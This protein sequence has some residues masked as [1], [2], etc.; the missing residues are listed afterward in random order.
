MQLGGRPQLTMYKCHFRAIETDFLGR[1][2]NPQGVKPEKK[3]TELPTE[4]KTNLQS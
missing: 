2:V 3:C 4:R 1:T